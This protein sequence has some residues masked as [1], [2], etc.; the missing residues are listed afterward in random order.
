MNNYNDNDDKKII[1]SNFCL[2]LH[3]PHTDDTSIMKRMATGN[4]LEIT[5]F[6]NT[7]HY[8]RKS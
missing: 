4:M 2:Q 6:L 5:I 7:Q 1:N 8:Q 3:S